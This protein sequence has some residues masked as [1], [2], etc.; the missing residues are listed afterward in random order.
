MMELYSTREKNFRKFNSGYS[1]RYSNSRKLR[2]TGNCN[3]HLY[4]AEQILFLLFLFQ[5]PPTGF[6]STINEVRTS[7]RTEPHY[8]IHQKHSRVL[9]EK[10]QTGLRSFSRPIM[11][12]Y[13]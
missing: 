7:N 11:P 8:D 6:I 1:L 10:Q 13:F 9:Y 5:T 2:I 3:P 12:K 4:K